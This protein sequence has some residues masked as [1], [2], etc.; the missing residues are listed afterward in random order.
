MVTRLNI[1][2]TNILLMLISL[3]AAFVLPFELVL[4]SYAFLGPAHYLTQI[5]WMHD[6]DYFVDWKWL[7]VPFICIIAVL[8]V[9]NIYRTEYTDPIAYGTVLLALMVSLSMLATKDIRRRALIVIVS[10]AFFMFLQTKFH[11]FAAAVII[12]IPTVVHIYIFTGAFILNGA[13]KSKSRWGV[14]SFLVFLFCGI[15]FLFI[16][17]LDVKISESFISNNIRSFDITGHLLASILSLKEEWGQR[18]VLGFLSF[19]YTYHYLNWFSK[20]ELIKWH[21]IPKRRM[22]I[23][24]A[25][26]ILSVGIYMVDY[27]LGLSVLFSLSMLHVFLEFPLNIL[28]FKSIIRR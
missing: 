17:P 19:A 21:L 5:S 26:Y 16:T 27:R 8:A 9:S 2:Q 6:R 22:G 4:I 25:L 14:A 20:V 18:G 7:W 12:L 1:D 15:A 28:T 3:A 23:I 24:V 10:M 11:L 13:I